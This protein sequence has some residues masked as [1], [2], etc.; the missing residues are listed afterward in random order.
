MVH[1]YMPSITSLSSVTYADEQKY[2]SQMSAIDIYDWPTDII[3]LKV[4]RNDG[5]AQDKETWM[6]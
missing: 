4:R 2:I 6:K 3:W 1:S 5:V